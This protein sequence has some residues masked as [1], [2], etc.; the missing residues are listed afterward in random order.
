MRSILATCARRPR[1]GGVIG[2]QRV[3]GWLRGHNPGSQAWIRAGR[4][5]VVI[6][7]AFAVAR[8]LSTNAQFGTFAAF[9]SFAL[10]L[11]LD[12]PRRAGRG[13]SRTG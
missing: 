10:L 11:F 5:A 4:A 9:G 6:P 8:A 13:C 7:V 2:V 1:T 12:P 3:L